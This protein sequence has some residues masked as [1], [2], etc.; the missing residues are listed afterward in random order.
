MCFDGRVR[1]GVGKAAAVAVLLAVWAV[2]KYAALVRDVWTPNEYSDTYY[3]F[4]SAEAALKTALPLASMTPEYPTP[5]AALLLAPYLAGGTGYDTYRW[6]FLVLVVGIDALFV[7]LLALRAGAAGV[8]AWTLLESIAGS[9]AL[10]RLDVV[11]AV[12]AASGLLLLLARR[13]AAASPVLAAGAGVKLWPALL[14]PLAL[15]D[16][17]TRLAAATTGGLA[18]ALLLG[19]SVAAAGVGRL[20]SP[21]AYQS[22]RG[23]QIESVAATPGMLAR[24]SQPGYGVAFTQW[25]A[26]ELSGPGV[27]LATSLA[28]SAG[29]AVAVLLLFLYVW[30]FRAGTPADAAPYIA[31]F[32][33]AAFMASSKALSPQYLLWLAAPVAVLFGR[34]FSLARRPALDWR[35]GVTLLAAVALLVLTTYVY[36]TH[37]DELLAGGVRAPVVA[38]A[39]R[40]V[41]LVAFAAWCALVA[42]G[43]RPGRGPGHLSEAAG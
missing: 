12:L 7:L 33:I 29:Y 39:A 4:L 28:T 21:L 17:R 26:Y 19:A 18:A 43:P 40:N 41:L 3:Y 14:L 27:E 9:L 16:R 38:L 35:A 32:A 10:L 13:D 36:P 8:L 25:H 34:S 24:L 15:G 22:G 5:A 23:L 20:L 6:N 1:S 2:A 30:W 37:Y 31:L 11:P 42:L